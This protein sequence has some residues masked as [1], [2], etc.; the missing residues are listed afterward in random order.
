MKRAVVV[1]ALCGCGDNA[2]PRAV[3]DAGPSCDRATAMGRPYRTYTTS[4]EMATWTG[5]VTLASGN[6]QISLRFQTGVIVGAN[7][8]TAAVN[9]SYATCTACVALFTVNSTGSVQKT[10]FQT[11]GMLTLSEDPLATRHLVGELRDASFVEASIDPAT[12]VVTP[13]AG[14]TCIR[15]NDMTLDAGAGPSGWT[16]DED[17]YGNGGSCDCG[18]GDYDPDCDNAAAQVTGCAAMQTCA[19]DACANTCDVLASPTIGC[20]AGTYCGF[21]SDVVDICYDDASRTDVAVV[22][23]QCTNTSA[24]FCGI[25]A[26]NVATGMCDFFGLD[27]DRCRRACGKDADCGVGEMCTPIL[28]VSGKGICVAA[29]ANDTCATATA[30][31][32]GVPVSG[33]TGGGHDDY[34]AGLETCTG[35]EQ[36]G[37]DAVY[38]IVLAQG[39]SI[40]AV[41]D[42]VS[43]DF[44]PSLA[45][46][47]ACGSP[48]TC[49]AGD[50]QIG[51][52]LGETVTFTAAVAGTYY[53]I[54]DSFSENHFGTFRLT[55]TGQ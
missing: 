26:K 24:L 7:D 22:G 35:Y 27:D 25:D 8:L 45:I 9:A 54:V 34:D 49:V 42:M 11:G 18:C 46:V 29:I 43:P 55:V 20:A 32:L 6:A 28:P 21:Y 53:V 47:S 48:V 16:C 44:D 1:L 51:T 12:G 13:I 23:G 31:A 14:G 33:A 30:L 36:P 17:G 40:S 41:V 4:T 3:T 5:P 50:D 37:A 39:Q 19:V 52:G 15:L 10:W 38:S 2:L